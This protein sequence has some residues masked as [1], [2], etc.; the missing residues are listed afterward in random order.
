MVFDVESIG[1]HGEGFSVAWQVMEWSGSAWM[2]LDEQWWRC[3]PALAQGLDS[4]RAWVAEQV[5]P[6][7]DQQLA[8]APSVAGECASPAAL[9]R[10]FWQSWLS[11]RARGA[12]LVGQCVWPVETNF[13]SACVRDL[14]ESEHF[15]GP[16]PLLD[17]AA[18]QVLKGQDPRRPTPRLV[19]EQPR[20]HPMADVRCAARIARECMTEEVFAR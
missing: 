20:H 2:V 5:L 12:W 17:I 11:W 13:L 1:L 14:G 4:D 8:G 6:M 15:S 10:C 19:D 9:R 18:W 3:D 7:L 16:Y